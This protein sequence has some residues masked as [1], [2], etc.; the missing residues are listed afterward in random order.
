[1]TPKFTVNMVPLDGPMPNLALMKLSAWHKEQGHKVT[2]KGTGGYDHV[3]LSCVFSENAARARSAKV[4]WEALGAEVTLGG[5]GVGYDN[6]LPEEV[7]NIKPDYDL[8]GYD[9]SMGFTSRGC[10]RACPFCIVPKKEGRMMDHHP[11]EHFHHP[12]HE[13]IIL[14]DNNFMASPRWRENIQYIQEHKLMVNFSQGLDIRIMDDEQGAALAAT[15]CYNWKF[16][17]P[18]I[19][20]AFDDP[21]IEPAVR[22]GIDILERNGVKPY[23]LMFYVLVGFNTDIEQD[24]HRIETLHDLGCLAYVMRYH[25]D[26]SRLNDLARWVNRRLHKVVPFNQYDSSVRGSA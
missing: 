1:M 22:R 26:D 17:T 9:Y 19:H 5:S 15:K 13:K 18:Q 21:K 2:L 8:Y 24:L 20:F 25:K 14:L 16:T 7:E 11:V 23:K 4:M 6:R 3:Y 10:I 12:E